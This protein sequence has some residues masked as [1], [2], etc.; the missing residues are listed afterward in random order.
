M[1]P[2]ADLVNATP[3]HSHKRKEVRMMIKHTKA[4]SQPINNGLWVNHLIR[5]KSESKRT[6]KPSDLVLSV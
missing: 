6:P 3:F 1:F 5:V 2:F 4:T